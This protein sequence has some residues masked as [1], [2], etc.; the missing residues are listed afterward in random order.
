MGRERRWPLLLAA[1]LTAA[2][3]VLLGRPAGAEI[4]V[5]TDA[6]G[7]QHFTNTPGG[8]GRHYRPYRGDAESPRRP[9]NVGRAV[10]PRDQNVAR[11]TRYDPWI[12]EAAALYQVPEALIRAI[13]RCESD[14]DPRAVSGAGA[15]GLMQLMPE[16]AKRLKVRDLLDPRDN[17]FGGVRLLRELANEFHGD[18]TL[19]IAAYNAG[20]GAV[21]RYAGVPPYQQTRD[22]VTAVTTY[23]RRYADLEIIRSCPAK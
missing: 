19:T 14:F 20:D 17:I 21:L 13:I 22:Y 4:F 8:D 3:V 7:V 12:V 16:P 11:F 23:Y 10:A 5:Y 9:A 15:R 2:A 18:L 6:N 1:L